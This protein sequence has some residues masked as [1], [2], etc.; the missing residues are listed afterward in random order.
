MITS[1]ATRQQWTMRGTEEHATTPLLVPGSYQLQVW[2]KR[3]A[4]QTVAFTIHS[5]QQTELELTSEVGVHQHL[6]F[7]Y[8]KD[9]PRPYGATLT[10]HRDETLLVDTWLEA[11][12]GEP[13]SYDLWLLPGTYRLAMHG[14]LKA[15]TTLT[16]AAGTEPTTKIELR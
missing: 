10:I 13:W 6:A 3:A 1:D 7:H 5:G 11:P 8:S 4:A 12:K 16:I 9:A 15:A 2:G 14:V